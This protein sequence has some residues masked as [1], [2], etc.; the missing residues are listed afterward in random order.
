MSGDPLPDTRSGPWRPVAVVAG[1]YL[2]AGILWMLL[3][4]RVTSWL[5]SSPGLQSRWEAYHGWI[6][7]VLSTGLL[8][9]LIRWTH[10]RAGS[11]GGNW[12]DVIENAQE[13][14][15]LIDADARTLHVNRVLADLLGHAPQEMRGRS[16]LEFAAPASRPVFEAEIGARGQAGR[17]HRQTGPRHYEIKLLARDGRPVHA[18]FHA[19][20]LWDGAGYLTGSYAFVTD[21][22]EIREREHELKLT[23]HT[24]EHSFDE[25][26]RVAPDARILDVN[27]TAI[28]ELGY[29]RSEL[30]GMS[31]P[32]IDPNFPRSVWPEHWAEL[33]RESYLRF[34]TQHRRKDGTLFPVEVGLAY[35][36]YQGEEYALAIARDIS[37]Q[38]RQLAELRR[39]A[40]VFDHSVE[41]IVIT[42]PERRI[43][44]VNDAFARITGYSEAEVLGQTP[45]ILH[46]GQQSPDFY[47]SM[48]ATLQAEGVWQG[49]IWN[50]RRNGEIYPEWLTISEVRDD[51]GEL[52]N[53]V[54]VFADMTEAH[55]AQEEIVFRTHH[56]HLTRLPNRILFQERLEHALAALG[57]RRRHVA[58]VM[59]D[60]IGFGAINDG[61]GT[62]AGDAILIEVGQRLGDNLRPAD[63]VARPGSDEFWL[64]LEDL[65]HREEIGRILQ[66]VLTKLG[67][68]FTT[69]GQTVRLA[70]R[71][72]VAL[73]P[74]D[75][76]DTG[77]LLNGAATALHR[78]QQEGAD[79][80]QYFRP[81]MQH[82]VRRRVR[83]EE[84]L[85]VAIDQGELRT[86]YQPQVELATGE[87]IAAEALV[88]WEHPAWGLVSPADFIPMA[89]E[90][91]LVVPLGA[92]VMNQALEQYS[93]W[94]S[95]GL[96]F[97]RVSVNV[98]AA[99]L[100][101]PADFYDTVSAGLKRTGLPGECLELEITEQGFLGDV[102]AAVET[103]QRL[104]TLD[105]RLAI[106]DFG[107]GY[108]SLAYLKRLPIQ[109][110]KIDK[111]FVD[112]LPDHEYD[113]SIVKAILAVADALDIEVVAEGVEHDSQAKW[114]S[115]H[116]VRFAQGF[117]YS[118]PKP[119]TELLDWLASS[120]RT[121]AP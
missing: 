62:D 60:I 47:K 121:G 32:D 97:R 71:A 28:T 6:F 58:V 94:R 59:L 80:V 36:K 69:A 44:A 23:R 77:S 67:E 99:Q 7:V 100:V 108:S 3:A 66:N 8:I 119:A 93:E 19:T 33:K 40:A 109:V 30:L 117:L 107:T 95:R 11:D 46:S 48:W 45:A 112:G 70:A 53:Y 91:G 55:Q 39:A 18:L 15:W 118:R 41:G 86:W 110:L 73:A 113:R 96:P 5:A 104:A 76:T 2:G 106:D 13:G 43:L 114:L 1:T 61:L 111:T 84:A 72:G 26:L 75:G 87:V 38:Q 120:R 98:A 12:R 25:I 52:V 17:R 21:L 9:A 57:H 116:G 89:E 79:E 24:L 20:S 22:T 34:E 68:P 50:R 85:K 35:L 29:S 92:W 88:R 42:D 81:D 105:V 64:L 103:I 16:P 90:T 4:E 101:R 49:E 27:E 115:G 83:L 54:G 78:A 82:Q 63:T 10:A 31:I 14:F 37:D 102:E 74:D 51:S 56:D 65:G